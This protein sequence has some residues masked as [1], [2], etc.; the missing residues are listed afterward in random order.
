M[1]SGDAKLTLVLAQ[2]ESESAGQSYIGMEHVLRG[3]LGIESVAAA[4]VLKRLNVSSNRVRSAIG[5]TAAQGKPSVGQPPIPTTRVR[6]LIE[7]ASDVAR[8][9][10]LKRR[11]MIGA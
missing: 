7:L 9:A 3:L 4:R 5:A 6:H 8:L 2:K 10:R 1:L 11:G